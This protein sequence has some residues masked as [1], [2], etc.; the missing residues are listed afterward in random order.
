MAPATLATPLNHRPAR[1]TYQ[2]LFHGTV[3]L[4]HATIFVHQELR[5]EAEG[6]VWEGAWKHW[7]AQAH[8]GALHLPW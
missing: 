2:G 5:R 8:P 7:P 3:P 4:H 6:A 1:G